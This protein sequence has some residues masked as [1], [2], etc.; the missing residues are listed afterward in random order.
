MTIKIFPQK[1]EWKELY[2]RL[3][4]WMLPV[5]GCILLF[6]LW[7]FDYTGTHA[8]GF[9]GT[10]RLLGD[11]LA[12]PV[13]VVLMVLATY[14]AQYVHTR[15][16]LAKDYFPD[17]ILLDYTA[18]R[19]MVYIT[20]VSTVAMSISGVWEGADV[21]TVTLGS[22]VTLLAAPMMYGIITVLLL[23]QWWSDRWF[24]KMFPKRP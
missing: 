7:H 24:A 19:G 1:G 18:R 11:T 21:T 4:L 10:P 16:L 20:I 5:G 3:S 15:P 8:L 2:H 9:R 23:F 6:W 13:W 22:V 12:F 17:C 14:F